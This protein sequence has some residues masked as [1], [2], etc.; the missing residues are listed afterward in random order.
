MILKVAVSE[1]PNAG[2]TE[3]MLITSDGVPLPTPETLIPGEGRTHL[4]TTPPGRIVID[5]GATITGRAA[6]SAGACAPHRE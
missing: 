6:S 3:T 1:M 5:Y 2:L 4:L